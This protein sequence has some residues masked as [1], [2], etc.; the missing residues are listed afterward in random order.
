M[1]TAVMEPSSVAEAAEHFVREA[2]RAAE[3]LRVLDQ[4]QLCAV[5]VVEEARTLAPGLARDRGE[6]RDAARDERDTG[7]H[8]VGVELVEVGDADA[9]H[10]C[11]GSWVEVGEWEELEL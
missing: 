7:A 9:A 2:D 8:D 11:A 4:V 10:E 5:D 1:T 6:T 3:L